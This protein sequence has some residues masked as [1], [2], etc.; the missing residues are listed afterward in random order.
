MKAIERLLW[1][2]VVSNAGGLNR[3]RIIAALRGKK[4]NKML[5]ENPP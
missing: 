4:S 3:G 1:W 5:E 2:L